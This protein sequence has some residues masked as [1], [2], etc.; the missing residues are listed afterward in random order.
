MVL[1][2]RE[3]ANPRREQLLVPFTMPAP[4]DVPIQPYSLS[5]SNTRLTAAL[6]W[7]MP[8]SSSL[9]RKLLPVP[10]LPKTP[11]E[12]VTNSSRSMQT[13]VSMSSGLPT[14]KWRLS[15]APNTTCTSS[16]E[17]RCTGAKCGGTV[18]G[19]RRDRRRHRRRA[20]QGKHWQDA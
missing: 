19:G 18:L 10:L 15:S 3:Y 2:E 8:A 4:S 9:V 11:L 20:F 6:F 16:S 7:R 5:M 17:A 14:Q 1:V 12:R 13:R